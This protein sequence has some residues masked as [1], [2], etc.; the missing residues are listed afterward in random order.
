MCD[1]RKMIVN[2]YPVK[3][4]AKQMEVEE[5]MYKLQSEEGRA[6]EMFSRDEM[7]A[8]Q[9]AIYRGDRETAL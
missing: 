2:D 7:S 6:T 5:M 4:T 1:I 3:T 8:L 9:D